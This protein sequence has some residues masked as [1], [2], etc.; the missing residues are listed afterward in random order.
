L[1]RLVVLTGN[2]IFGR[3]LVR[4]GEHLL[5]ELV[6]RPVVVRP[7][8]L[9][10]EEGLEEGALARKLTASTGG[11]RPAAVIAAV[12]VAPGRCRG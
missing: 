9:D 12:V 3:L 7:R 4:E 5:D 2:L 8:R 6:D 11:L 10:A 1:E